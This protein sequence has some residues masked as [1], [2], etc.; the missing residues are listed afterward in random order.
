M[1]SFEEWQLNEVVANPQE[2]LNSLG[3]HL[4]VP[5]PATANRVAD[6]LLKIPTLVIPLSQKIMQQQKQVPQPQTPPAAMPVAA[7]K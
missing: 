1:K 6:E 2:L 5:S 3:S 7:P 4:G